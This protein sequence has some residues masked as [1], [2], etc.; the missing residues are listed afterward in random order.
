[1][2]DV[3]PCGCDTSE[4]DD[5]PHHPSKS[6]RETKAEE[7]RSPSKQEPTD[8]Q[9]LHN[10]VVNARADDPESCEACE[11]CEY[12]LEG[13]PYS[14]VSQR[15]ATELHALIA[16]LRKELEEAWRHHDEIDTVL[17]DRLHDEINDLE[18]ERD[19][20]RAADEILRRLRREMPVGRKP[21]WM[22]GKLC[23]AL[24]E[25][26]S[27]PEEARRALKEPEP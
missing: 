10:S 3:M 7:K 16:D 17:I 12:P 25:Y 22:S 6:A 27:N 14:R 26:E 1:M 8:R 5:C 15:H 11:Y 18:R 2:S 23:S 13:S 19:S 24:N 21:D 4:L 20:L 9:G